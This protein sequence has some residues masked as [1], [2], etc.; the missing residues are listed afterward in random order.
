MG[1]LL[2]AL[3]ADPG[4]APAAIPAILANLE[5]E[6]NEEIAE[7]RESQEA[8]VADAR[9]VDPLAMRTYLLTLADAGRIDL[10][11]VRALSEV[12]VGA[13]IGLPDDTLCAYLRALCDARLRARGKIP[14]DETAVIR[15]AH[16]GPVYA[17]PEVARVLPIIAGMP[18]AAGCPWCFNRLAGKPIPRPS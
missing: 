10:A 8:D 3:I 14:S 2:A 17:A 1:R 16:C 13:C 4:T 18:T 15:C 6:P 12:D 7:S 5:H 9:I 11:L